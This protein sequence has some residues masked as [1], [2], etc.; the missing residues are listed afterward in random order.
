M[1][2][3][4]YSYDTWHDLV[5]STFYFLIIGAFLNDLDWLVFDL[6]EPFLPSF[7]QRV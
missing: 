6:A 7:S 3:S 4:M 5:K 2:H 1:I